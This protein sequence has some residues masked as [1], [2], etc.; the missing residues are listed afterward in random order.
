MFISQDTGWHLSVPL[1]LELPPALLCGAGWA[2]GLSTGGHQP[3]SPLCNHHDNPLQLG[4]CSQEGNNP[5]V[6]SSASAQINSPWTGRVAQLPALLL[7]P[8][9]AHRVVALQPHSRGLFVPPSV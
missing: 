8:L 4:L 3:P 7:V 1:G 5:A 2:L 6:R 9:P